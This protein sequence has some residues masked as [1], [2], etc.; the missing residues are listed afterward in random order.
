M[1]EASRPRRIFVPLRSAPALAALLCLL[2]ACASTSDPQSRSVASLEAEA[3]AA[4]QPVDRAELEA[5]AARLT[6]RADFDEAQQRFTQNVR[7]GLV[8]DAVPFVAPDLRGDF[9]SLA[10]EL[11][12]VRLVDF[13]VQ[14]ID[15]EPLG[16]TATATVSYSGY[17]LASPFVRD[18]VVTQS[19]TYDATDR[20]WYV[21]PDIQRLR[22]SIGSH[23]AGP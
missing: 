9:R 12:E 4:G 23:V 22:A 10:R 1:Q 17:W 14:E 13:V 19:W 6:W 18:L 16:K 2:A 15:L 20:R 11:R 8:D 3:R 5:K 21:R 7:W